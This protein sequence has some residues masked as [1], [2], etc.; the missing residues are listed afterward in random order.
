VSDSKWADPRHTHTPAS[1]PDRREKER[2][3]TAGRTDSVY[4]GG[5]GGLSL[6]PHP[7]NAS[8]SIRHLIPMH[9]ITPL[10]FLYSFYSTPQ[11]KYPHASAENEINRCNVCDVC[12]TGLLV[13][14]SIY[15]VQRG[16][17]K[18]RH[19]AHAGAVI[20]ISFSSSSSSQLT[21]K[22][23]NKFVSSRFLWPEK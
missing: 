12:C 22:L 16:V 9:I 15:K 1:T 6:D 20:L 2:K 18:C 17:Y 5:T 19:H 10:F 3:K 4:N 13:H 11:F 21:S 14:T 8:S 7:C 23:G